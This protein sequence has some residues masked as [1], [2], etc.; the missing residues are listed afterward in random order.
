MTKII[1]VAI[2]GIQGYSGQ[3]LVQLVK[4]HPY[5]NLVAAF[6]RQ[7]QVELHQQLPAL[8]LQNIPV[9]SY[10]DI[11]L[12][13][14]QI[15]VLFLATPAQVSIE[16]AAALFDNAIRIIDLSGGF[17]LPE[18]QF[19]TW[20]GL[21]HAASF[22][23]DKACYGLTPWITSQP[24]HQ[25]IANPGCY[26]TG[27]LMSLLPLLKADV[28]NQNTIIIDAKS[29][30][31]GSGKQTNPHLMFCEMANNFLPYKIGSHQHI[32]EIKSALTAVGGK[33]VTLRLTTSLLP[34]VRGIAMT[35]Y[36]EAHA[37]LTDTEISQTVAQAYQDAYQNYPFVYYQ[38]LGQKSADNQSILA[39]NQVI[40]TPHCHIGYFVQDGQITLF[41]SLDN[42][43]KG[44]A[45]QAI[46]NLNAAFSLPLS[47]GLLS[48]QGG[49]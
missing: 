16:I 27:A 2:A 36:G 28:L 46:E 3:V 25:L 38:A 22:L 49:L 40:G 7:T 34:L 14:A 10:E 44:A 5:L 45:S 18:E 21:K 15:D 23:I 6:S 31:S 47:T 13:I 48:L 26:A 1:N 42:L 30:V 39:L 8:K 17:R 32:P 24:T 11:K 41:T 9:Y 35:I 33:D 37:G 4:C 19:L 29:G 20:Y 43:L 12:C